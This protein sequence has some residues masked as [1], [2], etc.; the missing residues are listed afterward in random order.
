MSPLIM[1]EKAC[2]KRFAFL[3]ARKHSVLRHIYAPRPD[4]FP[5]RSREISPSALFTTLISSRLGFISPH[6]R[7][8]LMGIFFCFIIPR[9]SPQRQSQLLR[10]RE[11]SRQ[12]FLLRQFQQ[13]QQLPLLRQ[14][15]RQSPQRLA[16][17]AAFSVRLPEHPT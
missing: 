6:P 15:L 3:A 14:L 7:H 11:Q 13:Q 10:S 8:I 5:V 1:Q 4:F 17:P 2:S 16:T 12:L 9:C